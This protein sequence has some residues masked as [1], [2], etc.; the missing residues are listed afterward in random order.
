MVRRFRFWGSPFWKDIFRE[1]S[2][3]KGCFISILLITMLG[4][5]L[6]VGI[7]ATA[8][9]MRNAADVAYRNANLY[10]L[11]IRFP[12][13]GAVQALE[14]IIM[15]PYIYK[16]IHRFEHTTIFDVSLAI[17]GT[18]R[19]MRMTSLPSRINTVE[20]ISGRLPEAPNEI[21]VERRFL[22]GGQASVGG[23]IEV[24][25]PLWADVWLSTTEFTI[26]G[27]VESPLYL[28]GDRG[29]STLGAGTVHYYAYVYP[30]VFLMGYTDI[31]VIMRE[32]QYLH[33]VSHEYNQVV[34]EWRQQ[35]ET[36]MQRY[37]AF[38]FTRQNGTAFE[39]YFQDS[40]RLEQVGFVFPLLFFLVAVLVALTS[41]S[42]MVEEQRGQIGIYKAL[43]YNGSA[44]MLKYVVY[45]FFCGLAGGILGV[46]LGSQLIPRII[47][48]AYEHMY[49]MP[50][51]NHPIPWGVSAIAI[52]AAVGSIL[53]ATLLTCMKTLQGEAATLMRP[54]SPK[55]GKRVLL[56]RIPFIWNRMGFISKVTSRNIFRYKRRFFMT[57]AGVAGCTALLLVAFGL[58]DSIGSVAQVQFEDISIYDFQLHLRNVNDVQQ[59]EL[60]QYINEDGDSLF[61]R[62]ITANAHTYVGGFSATVIIPQDFSSLPNFVNLIT[63]SR[64]F[65][66]RG[67]GE[68]IQLHLY[69]YQ[70]GV[71]VTEKLAREM[72]VQVGDYFFLTAGDG[73]S[74]RVRVAGIV[75]NYVLHYIYMPPDYYMGLFGREFVPNGM[76]ATGIVDTTIQYHDSVLALVNTAF[77]RD[78]LS[79]QTD[80]L[81]VVTI[82]ILVMACILAFVVLF[83]LT[84]INIIER[85][86]E[87][88]TI[89]VLG[90]YDI[91]T[92]M[93][94]Y[95]ENMIVTIMGITLGLVG[96]VALNGFVL[97]TVE[98]DLLKFPHIIY[99]SSF[100]LAIGLSVLFALLV[101]IA[102]YH[103]LIGIDMVTALK[104]VE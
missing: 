28:T 10:D 53:A 91:E 30:E 24:Q 80:A 65:F 41:I 12:H 64:G 9:N 8:I 100:L 67:S 78:N 7:N 17:R 36:Y 26:V 37:G 29:N 102:T 89:K 51:S 23:T 103:R 59:D 33:Q 43:G 85:M 83:N 3:T 60:R 25:A 31:F 86:R 34:Q 55:A 68:Q 6:V 27:V 77:M 15:D 21:V 32:L 5:M 46:V 1:I 2:N 101:N 71:F 58:R 81:G 92:A 39:S 75:E 94:L 63:P 14:N 66:A 35:M 48:N 98:I 47:F 76:F 104:N 52:I 42:R 50:H 11:Q 82:V 93:Y 74:Y 62:T 19:I 54:K 40:L 79:N 87:I 73:L 90:F 56:E 88:A 84:E 4:A 16:S 22:R 69:R 49:N 70:D 57:L 13:G 44:I 95:R 96:G 99:P 38:V 97:T 20:L 61:I 45:A 18:E 72:D